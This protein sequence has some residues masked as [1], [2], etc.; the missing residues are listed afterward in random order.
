MD[1]R[2]C[3]TALRPGARFCDRCGQP[4]AASAGREPRDYTP[5]H[6]AERILTSRAALEGERKH[7]SVLFADVEGSME[8]AARLGPEEW[9]R[10][11]DGFFRIL[12][13]GVHRFEGTVNQYTG[14]GIMALFGAPIAHEDHAQ[15]SC[16]AALHL[17]R[18]LAAFA[19][20]FRRLHGRDF[21]VR[22]GI[23]S[24]EVVV[25]RIGDDLRMDYTAQ[26]HVVGLAARMEQLAEPG[27]IVVT[28]HVARRVGDFFRLRPLGRRQVAGVEAP[29]EVFVL[30][31][32]GRARTRLESSQVRGLSRFVGRADAM[33]TLEKALERA[34]RDGGLA[35]G[36][37]G[38]PGV[39]KS[40]LCLEFAARCRQRGIALW[41]A[42]CPPHGRNVPYLA[43]RELLGSVLGVGEGTGA[44]ETRERLASRSSLEDPAA[45]GVLLDLFGVPDPATPGRLDPG[46]WERRLFQLAIRLIREGTR[47]EPAVLLLDDLHWIDPASEG[48]V[49]ELIGAVGP[50]RVLLLVNFRL[51]YRAEWMTREPFHQLGLRPLG[52]EASLE[53]L[54]EL[55]GDDPSTARLSDRVYEHAGGNPFFI[56]EVV[57]SL[58]EPGK[59]EGGRG[60][61]TWL[62]AREP[63]MPE[64]VRQVLAARIDRLPGSDKELLQIASVVGRRFTGSILSR[65][66]QLGPGDVAAGLRQLEAAELLRRESLYRG[67]YAFRHP[68]TQEVAYDSLLSERRA[69]IHA[70]VASALEETGER[71]G[72]QAALIAHHWER[73]SR[74]YEAAR[75]R[76]RAAFRVTNLV[77]RRRDL[78]S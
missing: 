70:A 75:W 33:A 54:R 38:E 23:H 12:T 64:S 36:V 44:A 37:A 8:L 32:E 4:I 29:L 27:T 35:V 47:A 15:R 53:L 50:M 39:G 18:E 43:L 73:A 21:P 3:A 40:R 30:E 31:G 71:L 56:E 20:A 76:R 67:E 55:L 26:G 6:L 61:Y 24:G 14:D 63:E 68:L 10:S 11:L 62:G 65:L 60:A 66:T 46:E 1:C 5:R 77:P 34:G 52:R 19:E 9:H 7:V 49:S 78:R 2:H 74:P 59:L 57:R 28:E 22:M 13:G 42:H 17:S 58:V 45:L 25:G 69:G 72:E 16:H 51:E 41:E 48:F